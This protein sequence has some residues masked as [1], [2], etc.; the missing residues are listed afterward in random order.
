MKLYKISKKWTR[1]LPKLH[2]STQSPPPRPKVLIHNLPQGMFQHFEADVPEMSRMSTNTNILKIIKLN[3]AIKMVL[4]YINSST[5]K[6]QRG[7]TSS[8]QHIRPEGILRQKNVQS[9]CDTFP[10]SSR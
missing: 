9:K 6:A 5:A 2:L 1:L 4:G 7:T 8:A 3:L 10:N